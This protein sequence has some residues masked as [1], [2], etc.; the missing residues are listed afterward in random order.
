MPLDG[1]YQ[2]SPEKWVRDQVELYERTGGRE[3]NTLPGRTEP[4]VVYSTR[5]AKSGK[6]RKNPLMRI[7]HDGAYAMVASA[8]GAPKHPTWYFNLTAHP[9]QVTVQDG[10]QVWDGVA[11]EVTGE[12]KAVWWERAVAAFPDYAEYQ[13]RT[14][15]EI[16][17]FVVERAR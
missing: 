15:R 7:E 4:V 5:G 16:P 13:T 3:G 2:P 6:V 11:R 10:D 8:G 17:V 9:D 12:E 14:D 1:E